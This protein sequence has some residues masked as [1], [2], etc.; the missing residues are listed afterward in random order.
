MSSEN[1]I[2]LQWSEKFI[3]PLNGTSS[4]DGDPPMSF[5][6][7]RQ[8]IPRFHDSTNSKSSMIPKKFE[9]LLFGFFL[10]CFMSL[11]VSGIS[12]L[13]AIGL[14]TDFIN[15]WTGAWLAAWMVGFPAVLFTAPVVRR[16]VHRMV[17]Q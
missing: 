1:A 5:A 11:I 12:T 10:S 16:L 9:H 15:V 13:H 3:S 7:S 2:R 14:R 6:G 8:P 4:V 17:K